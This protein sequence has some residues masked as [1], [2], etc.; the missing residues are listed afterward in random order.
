MSNQTS[1]R[2]LDT[3][4][5]LLIKILQTLRG[6]SLRHGVSSVKRKGDLRESGSDYDW[7]KDRDI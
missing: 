6:S 1:Y 7:M 3:L 5:I 2:C 4:V